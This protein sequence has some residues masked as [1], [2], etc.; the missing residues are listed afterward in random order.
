MVESYMTYSLV[1]ESYVNGFWIFSI[2]NEE[3]A[4]QSNIGEYFESSNI[5]AGTQLILSVGQESHTN[6]ES[7]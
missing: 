6:T 7:K 4:W 1:C 3:A 5:V 2:L